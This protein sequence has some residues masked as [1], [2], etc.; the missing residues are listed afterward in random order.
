MAV[1]PEL[2]VEKIVSG[3]RRSNSVKTTTLASG[4]KIHEAEAPGELP[5]GVHHTDDPKWV[6]AKLYAKVK[7]TQVGGGALVPPVFSKPVP[8]VVKG[9]RA[10]PQ[11]AKQIVGHGMVGGKFITH[12]ADGTKEES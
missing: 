12:F 9:I 2:V 8:A 10:Q 3:S 1:E 11:P 4:I 7:V 6:H 5:K